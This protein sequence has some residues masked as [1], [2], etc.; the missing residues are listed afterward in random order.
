MQS[1][2]LKLQSLTEASELAEILVH[3]ALDKVNDTGR[4]TPYSRKYKKEFNA[5]WQG[6]KIDDVTALVTYVK[7]N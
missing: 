1:S 6:G 3:C 5:S 7:V 4:N 2:H